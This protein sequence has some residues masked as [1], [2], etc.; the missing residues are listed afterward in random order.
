MR[1]F[2]L[3]PFT[4]RECEEFAAYKKLGFTRLQIV[5]CYM[6]IGGVAYYWNLL[7]DGMSV[8]Q[9]FDS[10]FFGE[11]EEM[12]RE[13]GR[14]FASLFK[15]PT[16]HMA[17]VRALGK[18][19]SGMTRG[20]IIDATGTASCRNVTECLLELVQCGFLRLYH[21]IDKAKS[22]GIYQL[23]DPYCLFYFEFIEDWRGDDSRHWSRNYNSPRVN[24]WRGRAFERVCF[25][26]VPQIKARLGISG[27]EANAYSWRGKT[28]DDGLAQIDMLIDRADGVIDICEIKYSE[29]PYEL[30]KEED[31]KIVR[32]LDSFRRVSR[33]R[34]SIR[35]ILISASGLKQ[36]K[37]SGNIMSVVTGEDLFAEA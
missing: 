26:H 28:V 27:I 10:L 23:V 9:N 2:P 36:G 34:K 21:S 14:V 1:Q 24:S 30:S 6:A 7:Q 19:K 4:L 11:R 32:R 35:S 31:A 29:V 5:E 17:I 12:R 16:M 25:C 18:R 8:A 22:G 37:Y 15:S 13:F 33:T 20:D 3:K